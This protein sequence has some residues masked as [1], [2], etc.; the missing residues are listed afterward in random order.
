MLV[1]LKQEIYRPPTREIQV[2]DERT[3]LSVG[4]L[5]RAFAGHLLYSQGK[6]ESLAHLHD[7]YMALAYTIRDRLVQRRVQT[8]KTHIE[9]DVKMVYYLSL[10]FLMGRQLRNNL[11]DL[12]LYEKSRQFLGELGLE[13]EELL[14][15]ESEP[16]LGNGGL[17][18]LAACFMDS[19]A[20]LDIPARGYGIRYDFGIFDQTLSDGWQVESPDRWL[21]LGNPWEMPRPEYQV[22]VQFGGHTEAYTDEQGCY[23]VRWIPQ[24]TVF[25]L[26]YDLL[27][28]GYQS[29]TINSLRLWSARAS[30][31][32]NLQVFNGGD[33]LQAVADKIVSE[34]I[35][36]V[37]YPNDNNPQGRRLRLEQQYF[38]VSC[39]LQDI[40]RLY[41]RNHNTFEQF[42]AQVAIQLNDTHPAVA[43][44]ELM[45]LL[46][47][48][49][50][51][52]W[53]HSWSITQKTFAY[54]NHT[55]LPEALERWPVSLF[56]RLLPRHL[57]IIY[58]INRRFLDEV[59][60]RFPS[61]VQRWS[62][63]S[64]IEEG[65]EKQVRMAHL[66]CVGSH[67]VN[68]VAALHTQLL[69]SKTLRDFAQMWPQKLNN[70]TNGISQRRWLLLSNPRLARLIT[71]QLGQ[72]WI[73]ELT[74]LGELSAYVDDGEFRARW[75]QVKQDNKRELAEYIR[76]Q[77]GL[78][79]NL[80]SLFDIQVKRIH[81]Y[82]RQ[83]L[84]LLHIIALYNRM[85]K[86]PSSD[87]LP[88]TF[89]FAGKAAPGY[90][91]AKLII[92][93]INAVAEV[94]NNDPEVGEGLKIVFLPNFS[95]SLGELVYPAA[96]LSE[97]ISTAG[98]EASGTGN[99]KFALN[100]AVTIG[101]L[102]GAN[103]ELR[104]EVGA[105]NFFLFGLSVEQVSA[106]K[107]KGYNPW[108]Y[109]QSNA[110]LRQVLSQIASGSFSP[111]TPHLFQ[112]LVDK[113]LHHD[114]YLLLADYQSYADCHQRVAAAYRQ[115]DNWTKMSIL[116]VAR[117]GKFSSDRA[118]REYCQEIW[119]VQPIPIK[120]QEEYL[121]SI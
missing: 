102:D 49:Q 11:I 12:G 44:A 28:P 79:I 70:K 52:D 104:E 58:E 63:L 110:A 29:N 27:V 118:I 64:L 72:G 23:R 37:L 42:P 95:V 69:Q 88:R 43:I 90:Y 66:A 67:S 109:Y 41:L 38:F 61:D 101:T 93:L 76:H 92:K 121:S 120:C 89:I 77:Q 35:S 5:K 107:K 46:V 113:L 91:M 111:A 98:K 114:E 25:G 96:E 74:A 48:E 97:Q 7:Y 87:C 62:R 81:E 50:E 86:N 36:K 60:I 31:E 75:H 32:F 68:G 108:N 9:Q 115:P 4:S 117:M 83:L 106:L 116:N 15:Q 22:Q 17:G 16:G 85:K 105:E 56:G 34:N 80:A 78:E 3:G 100:G 45:R 10:E 18:R 112:P 40:I 26:P 65:D 39:S 53:E 8:A 19:L 2:E 47:D 24:R 103:I 84:N 94:I 14:A 6:Y 59:R 54:T 99:M 30:E 51:L 21:R 13:L 71:D 57:E 1:R 119:Q 82:K 55:L 33:Y 20:T 73:T